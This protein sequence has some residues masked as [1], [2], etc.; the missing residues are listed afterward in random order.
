[1]LRRASAAACWRQRRASAS[2]RAEAASCTAASREVYAACIARAPAACAPACARGRTNDH[3]CTQMRPAGDRPWHQSVSDLQVVQAPQT[4][5]VTLPKHCYWRFAAV[6]KHCWPR[7]TFWLWSNTRPGK[8][9]GAY[10]LVPHRARWRSRRAGDRRWQRARCGEDQR[11][12][13][14]RRGRGRGSR[15]CDGFHSGGRCRRQGDG[16]RAR[17]ASGR[18]GLG[19]GCR[20]SRHLHCG[21]CKRQLQA[22]WRRAQLHGARKQRRQLP[23]HGS[24]GCSGSSGHAVGWG[25]W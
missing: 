20:C 11:V 15:R 7:L 24:G 19:L 13:W 8:Q 2:R 18:L 3:C 16:R 5:S 25:G 4:A 1:M 23:G 9:R 22:G 17:H 12:G 21:P 6:S 14:R 10:R